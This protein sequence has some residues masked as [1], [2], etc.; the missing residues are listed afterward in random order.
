MRL[1]NAEHERH[2]WLI[3][4]IAPDFTLLD[5][6][7]LPADG[8]PNDFATL[9]AIVTSLDPANRSSSSA[10]R[11]LFSLRYRVGAWFGWDDATTKRPIP[12]CLETTLSQRVPAD[13]RDT[14]TRPT[15][16][17]STRF[18]PIYRT[19][20][21][22]A[23]EISNSTVHAVLQLAWVDQGNGVYRGQMGVYV[24]PRGRL[25]VPYM[26]LIG[27]FRHLIVYPALMRQIE[28]AWR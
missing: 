16:K 17:G 13:L 7:G 21:E 28:R 12:G 10:T 26:A 23:A 18:I 11:A 25:G 8:G 9:V 4:E 22:W 15:V 3:A 1:P 27:P 5:A 20:D 24:K 19:D 6:W 2:P 14:T